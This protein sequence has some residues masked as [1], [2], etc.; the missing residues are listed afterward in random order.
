MGKTSFRKG[1]QVRRAKAKVLLQRNLGK[2]AG[3]YIPAAEVAQSSQKEQK[4]HPQI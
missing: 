2:P 1:M 3:S 4:C